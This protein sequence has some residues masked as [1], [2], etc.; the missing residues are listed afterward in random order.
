MG[1]EGREFVC[2]I[3]SIV[4]DWACKVFDGILVYVF[5]EGFNIVFWEF[6]VSEFS[7]SVGIMYASSYSG[8]D[9]DEGVYFPSVVV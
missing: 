3:V 8:H 1:E 4:Q 5:H 2:C 6:E 7:Y 9:G